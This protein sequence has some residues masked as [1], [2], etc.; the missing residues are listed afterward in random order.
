MD[1]L[2]EALLSG[3]GP[4]EIG[5]HELPTEYEAAHL[6]AADVG[7]FDGVEDK[8]V[9]K[10]LHVGRVPM[11]ELAPDEVVV[12]VMA[13]SINYNTV[14]S[15]TFAP[16]PTFEF[17]KRGAHQGGYAARHDLPHHVVGSDAAGIVVRVGPGVRHWKAGD[18]VV[19]S[20]VQVD[21]QEPAT[22]AD[23][24][25]GAGQKIWGYETN[26]GGL[27]HYSVVRASQLLPKPAHL[28]WEESAGVLLTAA[29]SY[30]M[31]VGANGARIKQGDVVL[32]WGA[33]GG[34]GAFAVQM[35]KNAGGIAV[36][37][38]SAARKAEALRR[39]GCDVVI[40][41]NDIG[42]GGDSAPTPERTI[43]LGK[44][45]GREIRRQVG[46]DPH[47]VFDYVGR[48]TFGISVFVVRKG[49]TVVT[50]GSSTGYDHHFDNRY[51][52]MNL[53]RILG[54]HAAN[55]Q[56]QA[57][58]N[59]LFRLGHL[60]P[61]LSEVFPLKDVGEAARLV[62]TNRHTGKV[63]VL[64][65]APQEGLGVTDPVLREK[66]GAARLNPLRDAGAPVPAGVS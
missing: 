58:C 26:F 17:L 53:K 27:A 32:I 5:R 29:T 55:L 59:R 24:M 35:V 46:E 13:S 63:G 51:L 6:L 37:V 34:L 23:A 16:V 36:G 65:L 25:L 48:A 56:E 20:C 50:C 54:S 41:R 60:S 66:I 19:A 4:D 11:P 62:Q 61:I 47:V 1:S 30:R 12:A 21:E 42:M 52:W 57:E 2:T 15:A 14:W 3:A 44:R 18:H 9:R 45:L 39:L 22:H 38:V 31:L 64:C 43:E 8:D 10:S 28:T 40:D 49:G 33:T 7:M